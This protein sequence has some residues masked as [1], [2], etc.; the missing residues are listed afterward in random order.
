VLSGTINSWTWDFG[1]GN[2]S[3]D[4][5]P[6]NYYD[7]AGV[8]DVSLSVTTDSGCTDSVIIPVSIHPLPQADFGPDK[9]CTNSQVIFIDQS[10]ISSGSIS[11]W[12]WVLDSDTTSAPLIYHTFQDTGVYPITLISLS[13]YGCA[14][15][16][17][18]SVT[19]KE[20]PLVDFIFALDC[21]NT[22]IGFSD[23]SQISS[24]HS[25]YSWNWSFGD[26]NTSDINPTTH[27]YLLNGTY[28]VSLTVQSTNGCVA[29]FS[30]S[31]TVVPISVIA[32]FS[33][34]DPC[35]RIDHQFTDISTVVGDSIFL[36]NWKIDTLKTSTLRNPSITFQ[37]SGSYK[38][39][40]YVTTRFGCQDSVVKN[41]AVH[42]LPKV[43]FDFSPKFG[44]NP[45]ESVSFTNNTIN[46]STYSWNYGDSSSIDTIVNPAHAYSSTS[47]YPITLVGASEF[48][49]LDSIVKSVDVQVSSVDIGISG[50][51]M[52]CEPDIIEDI[53]VN[54]LNL[55]TR[56]LTSLDLFVRVEGGDP[57]REQ[58]TGFLG[59]KSLETYTFNVAF[60]INSEGSVN[61]VCVWAENPNN[62]IDINLSNNEICLACNNDFT[63]I[64]LFP[65]PVSGDLN[66]WFVL[67]DVEYIEANIFDEKGSFIGPAFS[68]MGIK[69]L[70]QM[71]LDASLIRRGIY[72]LRFEYLGNSFIKSFIVH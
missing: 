34:T 58:W 18:K 15:T 32:D 55:G 49:C 46:G 40:L 72:N 35:Y 9:A 6:S 1:D 23:K 3:T 20:G 48:G 38:V 26:G 31:V 10:T 21:D 41:I 39:S 17:T 57:I 7:S 24:P 68:G 66:I 47:V 45:G 22:A 63:I 28:N 67:P 5:N 37:D 53:T 51:T 62:T 25:I 65:N 8:Y 61:Y 14:D 59:P 64:D 11:N 33:G 70:N 19:I 69:G 27:T 16:M 52:D 4:T 43:D 12:T 30:D 2:L 29:I 44:V 36:W 54:I 60:P 56:E 42:S 71:T 13:D 50:L